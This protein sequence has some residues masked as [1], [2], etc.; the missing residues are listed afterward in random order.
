MEPLALGLIDTGTNVDEVEASLP[1]VASTELL[2]L[3][4]ISS[5]L[6]EIEGIKEF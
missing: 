1:I 2:D 6:V 5:T 4:L 3:E